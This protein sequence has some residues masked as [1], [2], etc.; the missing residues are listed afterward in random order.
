MAAFVAGTISTSENWLLL[1]G[2]G[3]ITMATKEAAQLA[4]DAIN[5]VHTWPG[6]DC[7]MVVKP[8]DAELQ[9]K[10]AQEK[11]AKK[12]QH[13]GECC[14]HVSLDEVHHQKGCCRTCRMITSAPV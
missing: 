2:Y 6:M 13:A 8:V 10:R 9:Q 11:Q 3:L 7:P 5:A 12:K 14:A 1:Q 4:M